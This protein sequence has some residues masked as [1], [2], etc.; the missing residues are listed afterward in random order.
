MEKVAYSGWPNCYRLIEMI[1]SG[2]NS[3]HLEQTTRRQ[4]RWRL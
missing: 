1:V 2:L 4:N 3:P